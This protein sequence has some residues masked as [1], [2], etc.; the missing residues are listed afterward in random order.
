MNLYNSIPKRNDIQI[1]A[2]LRDVKFYE[3]VMFKFYVEQFSILF[4]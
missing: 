3:V 2:F 4:I 1:L